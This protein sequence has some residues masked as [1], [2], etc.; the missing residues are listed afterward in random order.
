MASTPL[1]LPEI[2]PVLKPLLGILKSAGDHEKVDPIVTYW[3]RLYAFQLGLSIDKKSPE[4]LNFLTTIM[5][6]LEK[7]KLVHK[8]NEAMSNEL[9]A[10]A[11]IE[12]HAMNLF[13]RADAEDRSS[14]AGR[15]TVKLYFTASQLFDTLNVF[16]EV[17]EEVS[18]KSKYA[19]WRAAYITR[20]IRNGET[21]LPPEE[22]GDGD[23]SSKAYTGENPDPSTQN[24]ST[25]QDIKPNN[26]DF[27]PQV[28]N[29]SSNYP[30]PYPGYY[31]PPGTPSQPP[32][33][34]PTQPI[35]PQGPSASSYGLPGPAPT[36]QPSSTAT[37][38]SRNLDP[39]ALMKAQKYCKYA[40][41][42]LQ[43]E[44]VNTAVMNL[45]K[46]LALLKTTQN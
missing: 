1:N 25:V 15:N 14:K 37:G 33:T 4:C 7:E 46:A 24:N 26:L 28:P 34:P 12:N 13:T 27:S 45:E 41:S 10:Q 22:E 44:D 35:P 31:P 23:G 39:E 3:C 6:W 11:H 36:A 29:V 32:Y 42:A 9:V 40:G 18:Q 19:K 16:G 17:S 43:F 2:P 20:C 38:A 21:P 8:D 5:A 30:S